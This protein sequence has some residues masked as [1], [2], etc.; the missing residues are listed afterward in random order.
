MKNSVISTNEIKNVL[1]KFGYEPNPVMF[2]I[3]GEH[4]W[5]P[6]NEPI[7]LNLANKSIR[8]SELVKIKTITELNKLIK[9]KLNK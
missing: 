8:M 2:Q 1:N 3:T 9:I 7:D 5:M 6:M 4:V